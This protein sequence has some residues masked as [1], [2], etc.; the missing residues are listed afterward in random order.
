V[1]PPGLPA[2]PLD[3]VTPVGG[4][5]LHVVALAALAGSSPKTL[6]NSLGSGL[7]SDRR[8]HRW[9]GFLTRLSLGRPSEDAWIYQRRSPTTVGKELAARA[10]ASFLDAGD[11]LLVLSIVALW[12]RRRRPGEARASRGLLVTRRELAKPIAALDGWVMMAS[13][14]G[15]L[16]EYGVGRG[17]IGSR[18]VVAVA[19]EA[20]LTE[21]HLAPHRARG[22]GAAVGSGEGWLR[23]VEQA[24]GRLPVAQVL[25]VEDHELFAWRVARMRAYAGRKPTPLPGVAASAHP[26]VKLARAI[27]DALGKRASERPFH[28]GDPGYFMLLPQAR[29]PGRQR[30]GCCDALGASMRRF[31]PVGPLLLLSFCTSCVE[32]GSGPD[33]RRF[34][35]NCTRFMAIQNNTLFC[36][37]P[38]GAVH[39]GGDPPGVH[40]DVDGVRSGEAG[41]DGGEDRALQP[42]VAR[43]E[44]GGHGRALVRVAAAGVGMGGVR[45]APTHP[46]RGLRRDR[47]RGSRRTSAP[48]PRPP[49]L[50]ALAPSSMHHRRPG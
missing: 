40:A 34:A 10:H 31:L 23:A 8:D 48:R 27:D 11:A 4:V 33:R 42:R 5:G 24:L 25:G 7:R 1:A 50:R 39:G 30:A 26:Y 32:K 45:V 20:A 16:L 29:R 44:R 49:I 43:R 36:G 41:A 14:L 35:P 6:A 28:A 46:S 38:R 2:V 13:Q 3:R 19:I 47:L 9:L 21:A 22:K 37:P 12:Q 17:G 18:A 15:P